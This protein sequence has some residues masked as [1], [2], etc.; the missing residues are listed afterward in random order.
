MTQGFDCVTCH[1]DETGLI[2]VH[3]DMSNG[4]MPTKLK[5]TSVG[6]T[7]CQSCHDQAD[8]E[9][10]TASSTA[11][12]DENGTVMNPHDM[13]KTTITLSLLL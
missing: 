9:Q 12:V 1:V 7:L 6:K 11:L 10:K 8:L 3:K 13:P 4:K 2:E 5:R